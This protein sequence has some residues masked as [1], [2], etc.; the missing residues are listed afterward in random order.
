MQRIRI[1]SPTL[2]GVLDYGAAA[3]LL[4]LPFALGLDG[5]A[6]WLSV[7][8]GAALVA[9][10]LLTDYTLALAPLFS[11]RTHLVLDLTA[12]ALFFASPM[13][14]GFAGLAAGYYVV[15]G[16]GVLVV[17][18]LSDPRGEVQTVTRDGLRV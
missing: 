8:G 9:Y 14:F 17:V 11:F 16:A 5:L 3:A 7:A 18:A 6:R 15:M 12:A 4:V 10:S 2:H 13:L 1:L